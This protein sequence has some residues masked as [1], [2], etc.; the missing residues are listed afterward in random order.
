MK[1]LK[2]RFRKEIRVLREALSP[3][4]RAYGSA[5]INERLLTYLHRHTESRLLAFASIKGEPDLMSLA[6]KLP[7]GRFLLPFTHIAESRLSFHIWWP[8]EELVVNRYGISEPRPLVEQSILRTDV[9][10]VPALA[11]SMQGFRLGYGGG[12]YDRLLSQK[13]GIPLGITYDMFVL[14]SLPVEAHDVRIMKILT[15]QRLLEL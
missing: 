12:Y 14:E 1:Q 3:E 10:A 5:A 13:S 6:T 15:D 11:F 8:G 9:I 2:I 7:R 4:L